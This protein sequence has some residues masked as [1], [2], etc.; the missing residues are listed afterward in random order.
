V[1][2]GDQGVGASR[3]S[4]PQ[5]AIARRR[6]DHLLVWWWWWWVGFAAR[7]EQSACRRGQSGE[8]DGLHAAHQKDG[9]Q[10]Q[11]PRGVRVSPPLPPARRSSLTLLT[12]I[13]RVVVWCRQLS[14]SSNAI[15][16]I[17]MLAG[18][19]NLKILSL[20]RNNITKIQKLDDVAGTLEELW[21]SYNQIEKLE[22]LKN[23]KKLKKLYIGN[24]RLKRFDELNALVMT[25]TASLPR[26]LCFVC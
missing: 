15:E 1:Q 24:N 18:L 7:R 17:Q 19:K 2:T 11:R 23:L 6:I 10:T 16:K 4:Q 25:C 26:T 8:T 13:E 21:I 20:S 22:G 14:L 9:Q 5:H 12:S 3:S